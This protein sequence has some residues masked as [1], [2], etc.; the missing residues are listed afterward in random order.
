MADTPTTPTPIA[1]PVDK[2]PNAFHPGTGDTPYSLCCQEL[3]GLLEARYPLI[4]LRSADESRAMR[5]CTAA[6][7]HLAQVSPVGAGSMERWSSSLGFQ[8]WKADAPLAELE[9][10]PPSTSPPGIISIQSS[11]ESLRK[12]L[13][14]A[15][16]HHD[17]RYLY[18]L[19]DWA[20]LMEGT[21]RESYARQLKELALDIERASAQ[22]HMSLIVIASDWQIPLLLRQNVHLLDLALPNGEELFQRVF[23]PVAQADQLPSEAAH[24]LAEQSQGISLQAAQQAARLIS[25]QNLW[26]EPRQAVGLLLE[27][28]KQE[29]RKTGILEYYVPRGEGLDSVGGLGNLKNWLM[30][31]E[32]WFEQDHSPALRP[33]AI[34]LEG[35]PGCGKTLIARAIAQE[36]GVP[37]INFEISRLQSKW[38][39]ESESQTVE[40]LAAIEASSP[41]ILFVDEIEKAFAGVGGDSSG[42]MTR[43]LGMF[44]TWLNDHNRPIFLIATSNDRSQL[45]P[46]LFRAG[47]FDEIFVVMPPDEIERTEILRKRA[48]FYGVSPVP[49]AVLPELVE[50]TQGFS[51]AELDKL[52]RETRYIAGLDRKPTPEQWQQSLGLITPQFRS[53]EMQTLLLRY[54]RLLEQGGGRP[55]SD[56]PS[57]LDSLRQLLILG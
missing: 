40:A 23:Q 9:W 25:A 21:E 6:Y 30:R 32:A 8:K 3:V 46:E 48:S 10:E 22:P 18:L 44:L 4:F 45:P 31:R 26:T 28:K 49:D 29:I 36:W 39:G 15:L 42:I 43:Q 57:H 7:Q 50:Q 37:Q 55:A 35:F 51:G 33:R 1:A 53:A 12:A 24:H 11:L 2:P 54:L 34:L 38:A 17:R 47:R 14:E 19:P 5:C 20:N 16:H 27:V 56:N 41:N 52:V 13:K